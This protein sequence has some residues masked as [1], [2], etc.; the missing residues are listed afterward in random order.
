LLD[1]ELDVGIT[2]DPGP[3]KSIKYIELF[4]DEVMAVVPAG[5]ALIKKKHLSADDIVGQVLIFTPTL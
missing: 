5:H 2:S 3:D 1:N 4:K